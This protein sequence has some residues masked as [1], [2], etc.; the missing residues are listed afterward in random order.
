MLSLLKRLKMPEFNCSHK[1]NGLINL[2]DWVRHEKDTIVVRALIIEYRQGC[3]S[4]PD[5]S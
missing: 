2:A 4:S 5:A 1:E 3:E